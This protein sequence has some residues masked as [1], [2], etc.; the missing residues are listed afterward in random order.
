MINLFCH[1]VLN[2]LG[3]SQLMLD[4]FATNCF[5]FK[6]ILMRKYFKTLRDALY[7]L[8]G[9]KKEICD[10]TIVFGKDQDEHAR[11]LKATFL[12]IKKKILR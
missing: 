4:Y 6:L 5:S 10:D 2:T 11:R 7:G 1:K 3:I 9:V 12:R 8:K